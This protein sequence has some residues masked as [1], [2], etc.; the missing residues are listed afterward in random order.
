MQ[1]IFHLLICFTMQQQMVFD[2]HKDADIRQWNIVDD[3]VMGGLSAGRFRINEAGHGVFTG[4]VSLENNGGFSSLRYFFNPI[5]TSNHSKFI[6]RL[7]GD[8]KNYQFRV[9]S[10]PSEYYSYICTFTTTGDWQTVEIP[11]GMLYPSFRGQTLNLP[12]YPG[13]VLG[14]IGFLIGNKKAERFQLEI[15]RIVIE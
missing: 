12:N 4:T 14:E 5:E 9:K 2:F 3:G 11:F 8:G 1:A 15:D 10:Q 7:K 13:N 6:I